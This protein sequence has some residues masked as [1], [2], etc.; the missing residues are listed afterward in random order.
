MLQHEETLSLILAGIL[1]K[2]ALLYRLFYSKWDLHLQTEHHP[3][4]TKIWNSNLRPSS[5][6]ETVY[7]LNK[8]IKKWDHFLISLH[9]IRRHFM[10][11]FFMIKHLSGFRWEPDVTDDRHKNKLYKVYNIL[12]EKKLCDKL[13]S[14]FVS[15]CVRGP[16]RGPRLPGNTLILV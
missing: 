8:S 11:S 9:T 15:S 2:R 13:K 7:C 5:L 6:S 4:F 12:R 14:S 10:C 16:S 1:Q 3:T